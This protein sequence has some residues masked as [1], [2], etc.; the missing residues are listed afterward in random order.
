MIWIK[1]SPGPVEKDTSQTGKIHLPNAMGTAPAEV[2]PMGLCPEKGSNTPTSYV[3]ALANWT[4]WQITLQPR[5]HN[6]TMILIL[7]L[8]AAVFTEAF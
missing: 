4:M 5:R 7:G 8:T 1:I 6:L 2:R 3:L